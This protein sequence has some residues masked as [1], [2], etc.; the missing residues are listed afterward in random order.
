MHMKKKDGSRKGKTKT[1]QDRT[2]IPRRDREKKKKVACMP[3]LMKIQL[4][5]D[6]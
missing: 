3:T 1:R 4:S 2:K 6:F 5:I